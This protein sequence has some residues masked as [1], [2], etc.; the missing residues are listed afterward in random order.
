MK[1][2]KQ[3][4][5]LE[6]MDSKMHEP[7]YYYKLKNGDEIISVEEP[8][9]SYK[10]GLVNTVGRSPSM[11]DKEKSAVR[12]DLQKELKMEL[13][14]YKKTHYEFHYPMRVT[15]LPISGGQSALHMNFWVSPSVHPT[16]IVHFPKSEVLVK[17]PVDVNVIS[18]YFS[19][20]RRYVLTY[21]K[22]L[23]HQ[24]HQFSAIGKSMI[25]EM[26]EQSAMEEELADQFSDENYDANNNESEQTS[27]D[28]EKI[29]L[30]DS[31]ENQ[32]KQLN[33]VPQVVLGNGLKKTLH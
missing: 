4:P 10:K 8:V 32:V 3:Q 7:V 22:G 14:E 20:I 9:G 31:Q 19:L 18:Y 29:G 5:L 6:T 33:Q 26:E 28:K 17:V 23:L 12:A 30:K 1:I 27:D 11:S 15:T 24:G 25:A 13:K 2:P 21:A 16:Q